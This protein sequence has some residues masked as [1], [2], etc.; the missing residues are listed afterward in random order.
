VCV[1]DAVAAYGDAEAVCPRNFDH[2]IIWHAD[3][4]VL[5][6]RV[7]ASYPYARAVGDLA[8]LEI[9]RRSWAW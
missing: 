9:R 7:I 2:H 1:G 4:E 5:T 3:E 8:G 6:V